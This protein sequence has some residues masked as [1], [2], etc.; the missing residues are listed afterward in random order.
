MAKILII[1]DDPLMLRLYHK[2]FTMQGYAV[3]AAGSGV[4]GIEKAK[5]EQPTLILLDIMMPKMDGFEVLSNL[6]TDPITQ[7]IP[8]IVLTN[9]AGQQ[10]AERALA[11]GAVKYIIKSEQDPNSVV[12]LVKEILEKPPSENPGQTAINSDPK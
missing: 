5:G 2:A 3:D 10:D 12:K 7:K 4:E 11:L 9:L 6:K 1:E 8:V